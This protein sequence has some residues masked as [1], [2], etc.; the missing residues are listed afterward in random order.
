LTVFFLLFK[1]EESRQRPALSIK[2]EFFKVSGKKSPL[3]H[4]AVR[5]IKT[6]NKDLAIKIV[7]DKALISCITDFGVAINTLR[8]IGVAACIGEKYWL[9]ESWYLQDLELYGITIGDIELGALS[10]QQFII[11]RGH[12]KRLK[13]RKRGFRHHMKSLTK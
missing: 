6:V 8:K 5:N 12:G 11:T 13:S 10:L 3:V 2:F 9:N 1:R 7:P 4:L